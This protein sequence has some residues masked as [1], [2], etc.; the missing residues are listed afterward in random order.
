M[1][2]GV[3]SKQQPLGVDQTDAVG[4]RTSL[5]MLTLSA[6]LLSVKPCIAVSNLMLYY[7]MSFGDIFGL[8]LMS[9]AACSVG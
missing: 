4:S 3:P 2:A 6:I 5:D 8:I 1:P 7:L 9:V